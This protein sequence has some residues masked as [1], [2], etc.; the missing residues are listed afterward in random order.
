MKMHCARMELNKSDMVLVF[1]SIL[2]QCIFMHKNKS[3]CFT[4]KCDFIEK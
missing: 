1:N 4:L 3:A 2:A